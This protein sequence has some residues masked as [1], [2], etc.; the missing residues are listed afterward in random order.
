MAVLK[1]PVITE[2]VTKLAEKEKKATFIVDKK[3][4]KARKKNEVENFTV[5]KNLNKRRK[6]FTHCSASEQNERNK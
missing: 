2:K 5:V 6:T 1:K 4:T 3:E